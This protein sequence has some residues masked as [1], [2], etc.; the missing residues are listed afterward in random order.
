[1]GDLVTDVERPNLGS[2]PHPPHPGGRYGLRAYILITGNPRY[3]SPMPRVTLQ[4]TKV[5]PALGRFS[6]HITVVRFCSMSR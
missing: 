2:L 4:V 6:E 3:L 5:I 1:M